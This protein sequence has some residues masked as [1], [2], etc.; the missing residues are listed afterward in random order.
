MAEATDQLISIILQH[1]PILKV[2]EISQNGRVQ[3]PAGSTVSVLLGRLGIPA[4]QQRYLIVYANGSKQSLSYILRENDAV[5][6]F[7]PIGGG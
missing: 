1:S 3:I 4:N 7:L 6:L 5:Q 2:W